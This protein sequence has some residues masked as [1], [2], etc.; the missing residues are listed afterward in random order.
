MQKASELGSK[1]QFKVGVAASSTTHARLVSTDWKCQVC[2]GKGHEYFECPTKKKLDAFAKANQD[3]AN[4]GQWKYEK[5]YSA[6]GA[7]QKVKDLDTARKLGKK[8]LPSKR[9]MPK[10]FHRSASQGTMDDSLYS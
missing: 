8:C 1:A 3:S 7:D 2:E 5:Y 4:W 6:I 10:R 9:K